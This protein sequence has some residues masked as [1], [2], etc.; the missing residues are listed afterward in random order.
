MPSNSKQFLKRYCYECHDSSTQEGSVDLEEIGFT[1]S[2]DVQ[3]AERWEYQNV[4][5]QLTGVRLDTTTLPDDQA[6]SG[7]DTSGA[8][9][10]FSRDQL[11]EYLRLAKS[12]LELSFFPP[13]AQKT[14]TVLIEPEKRYLPHYTNATKRMCD[15]LKQARAWR[16]QNNTTRKPPSEF[17]FLDEYQVK[18]KGLEQPCQVV[19]SIRAIHCSTTKPYRR[20]F[21]SYHQ[22]RWLHTDKIPGPQT[23][24]IRAI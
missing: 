20:Y 5:K 1:I 12:A 17:G 15:K 23:A 24:S 7:F 8:S 22:R 4:V 19:A 10:F 2:S 11:E 16:A 18:K 9:L 13:P 6:T 21:D 3:T 14:R